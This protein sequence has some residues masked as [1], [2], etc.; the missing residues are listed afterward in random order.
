MNVSWCMCEFMF[1]HHPE[2]PLEMEM[3]PAMSL[4][5]RV[6]RATQALL[7]CTDGL[8]TPE[9]SAQSLKTHVP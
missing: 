5:S 8:F 9:I 6:V 4:P 3:Q 7:F 1:S 2:D